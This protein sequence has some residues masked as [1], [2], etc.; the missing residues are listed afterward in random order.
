MCDRNAR[1]SS[2]DGL[3]AMSEQL[4]FKSK[5]RWRYVHSEYNGAQ[6]SLRLMQVMVRCDFG[7]LGTALAVIVM[8][9]KVA[10]LYSCTSM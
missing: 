7:N 1:C 3:E 9:E 5:Y 4:G 2:R 6:K 8:E 10:Q